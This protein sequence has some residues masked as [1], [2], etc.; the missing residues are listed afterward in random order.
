[1]N[2]FISFSI[3]ADPDVRIEPN[4]LFQSQRVIG[5]DEATFG[6]FEMVSSKRVRNT[7]KSEGGSM[8]EGCGIEGNNAVPTALY[9][10]GLA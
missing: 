5:M 7:S 3:V 2:L 6:T 10:Y 9:G 1:M 8:V 4:P